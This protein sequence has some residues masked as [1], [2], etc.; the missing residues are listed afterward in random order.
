VASDD[1]MRAVSL[2]LEEVHKVLGGEED[3]LGHLTPSDFLLITR[4]DKTSVIIERITQ[5]LEKSLRYF[6]RDQDRNAEIFTERKLQVH[7]EEFPTDP[8]EIPD[9]K[10]LQQKLSRLHR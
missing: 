7:I 6:Y 2:M 9:M 1:L 5:R 3:F 8:G 4:P 10:A